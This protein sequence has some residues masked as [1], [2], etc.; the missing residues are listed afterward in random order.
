MAVEQ[1]LLTADEF[2]RLP[3]DGMRHELID[4]AVRTMSPPGGEHGHTAGTIHGHVARFCYEH[5]IAHVLAAETGFVVRQSPDR[6][7]APDVAV[8][9]VEKVPPGGFP[10]AYIPGA[11]D[12]AVEVVSPDDTASEVL[13]KVQD[14]LDAGSALVWAFYPVGPRLVVHRP[15][16]S[17]RTLGPEDE[18]DGGDVLPG[19]RMRVADLVYPFKRS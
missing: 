7:R 17:S 16:G 18:V 14:W 3:D 9:R 15:D 12:L 19:F 8:V 4:G 11:P 2:Y 13:E 1:R 5:P 10:E 6:V